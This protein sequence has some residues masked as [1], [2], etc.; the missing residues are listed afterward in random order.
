MKLFHHIKEVL[1]E[2][3]LL[4]IVELH[5]R[6]KKRGVKLS[7]TT[8]TGYLYG[9]CDAGM[10]NL[11]YESPVVIVTLKELRMKKVDSSRLGNGK[12]NYKRGWRKEYKEEH[13]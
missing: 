6:L 11:Y 8:L 9:L 3:E 4:S 5:R 1:E 2:K 13:Q 10:I 12:E 7:K